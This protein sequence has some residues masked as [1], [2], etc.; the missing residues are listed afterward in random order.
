MIY[1]KILNK[2]HKSCNGG[3]GKWK[4]NIWMPKLELPLI[5]CEHG[6]HLC[7]KKDLINWLDSEIWVAE[8]RG[9]KIICSDKVVFQEARIVKKIQSWNE[10]TIRLFACDCADHVL[11]NFEDKY[12]DDKRVRNCID[13]ARDYANGVVSEKELSTAESAAW[14]AAESAAESAAWSAAGSAAW[15]AA[16]SARSAAESAAWSAAWSAAESAAESAAWSA[17]RSAAG[18]AAE[19]AAWSAARSAARSAA[20]SAARSAES[21]EKRWQIKQLNKYLEKEE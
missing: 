18:S 12:P 10:K 6:Y 7:R 19:S 21:A 16:E 4:P 14:S 1:Y 20:W 13:V 3:N 17:A 11:K 5:P 9:K 15:S 2:E 8:G